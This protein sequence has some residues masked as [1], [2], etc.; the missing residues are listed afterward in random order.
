MLTMRGVHCRPNTGRQG[1][2]TLCCL[3][4]L[5]WALTCQ[6]VRKRVVDVHWATI[7]ATLQVRVHSV[8]KQQKENTAG[9][10]RKEL[11]DAQEKFQATIKQM[12]EQM[13]ELKAQLVISQA[14]V[15]ASQ[16]EYDRV[17]QQHQSV[18]L[19]LDKRDHQWKCRSALASHLL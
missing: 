14:E 7:I 3:L 6:L 10:Y 18:V 4:F 8:L 2:F 15:K 9:T 12:N 5:S 19:E 11:S 16:D 1:L 17:A 13:N